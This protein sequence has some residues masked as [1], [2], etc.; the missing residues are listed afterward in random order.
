MMHFWAFTGPKEMEPSDDALET[1]KATDNINHS[2][3]YIDYLRYFV[4][5]IES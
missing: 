3:F 2:S 4:I 5:M 1:S